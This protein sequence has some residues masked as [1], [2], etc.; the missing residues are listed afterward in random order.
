MGMFDVDD[1]KKK[2]NPIENPAIL[3]NP[4]GTKQQMQMDMAK[5]ILRDVT[6]V[7]QQRV[8]DYDQGTK[9]LLQQSLDESKQGK[10]YFQKKALDGTYQPGM[11]L[12]N[13]QKPDMGLSDAALGMSSEDQAMNIALMDRAKKMYEADITHMTEKA[14]LQSV[15]DKFA[16]TSPAL[17][18]YTKVA[19][20][21]LLNAQRA[22]NA[23][24]A[25]YQLRMSVIG[26]L[27][28]L[29]GA[30]AGNVAGKYANQSTSEGQPQQAQQQTATPSNQPGPTER[31]ERGARSGGPQ[32]SS[33]YD[34]GGRSRRGM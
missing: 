8:I 19:Q 23:A 18:Q 25:S 33:D 17:S 29:G 24:Q 11:D 14:R 9:D 28:S 1:Y 22:N 30:G 15:D 21:N 6:K 34:I 2:Y 4:D 16:A 32:D 20:D 26:N 5:D 27:M 10:E 12:L 7:P 3:M 13:A 31:H